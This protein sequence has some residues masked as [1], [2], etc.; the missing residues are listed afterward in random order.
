MEGLY[1][2]KAMLNLDVKSKG[3]NHTTTLVSFYLDI[4]AINNNTTALSGIVLNLLYLL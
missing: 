3:P 2:P 1:S 4:V